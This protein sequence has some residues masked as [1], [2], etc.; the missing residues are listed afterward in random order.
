MRSSS[1]GVTGAPVAGL[2]GGGSGIGRSGST[3]YQFRGTSLAPSAITPVPSMRSFACVLDFVIAS[4]SAPPFAGHKKALRISGGLVVAV[5]DRPVRPHA[6]RM[7]CGTT[8]TKS[9]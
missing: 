1:A 7:R 5:E 4:M 9:P 3:L 2:I 6:L 8:T